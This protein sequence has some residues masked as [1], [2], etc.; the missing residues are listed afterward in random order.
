MLRTA[1]LGPDLPALLTSNLPGVPAVPAPPP[2]QVLHTADEREQRAPGGSEQ[3]ER[4]PRHTCER[5]EHTEQCEQHRHV[6]Q[7]QLQLR[8]PATLGR[9]RCVGGEFPMPGS[10]H[11]PP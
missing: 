6:Q 4:E 2:Q 10:G 7:Q 9:D 5:E 1:L 3:Y 8:R 11:W